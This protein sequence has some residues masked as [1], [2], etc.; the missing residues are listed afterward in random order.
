MPDVAGRWLHLLL[1][2]LG[3]IFG[4]D[5]SYLGVA[6]LDTSIW[7][8]LVPQGEQEQ[9][10]NYST[11]CCRSPAFQIRQA[12]PVGAQFCCW[13]H[14]A[15]FTIAKNMYSS[16]YNTFTYISSIFVA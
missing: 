8:V 1:R 9:A 4:G 12:V 6:G 14:W 11:M 7:D 15:W 2:T 16:R 5:I 3:G 10:L 13:A